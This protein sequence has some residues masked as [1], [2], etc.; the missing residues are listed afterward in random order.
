[1]G[2]KRE[3]RERERERKDIQRHLALH[4]QFISPGLRMCRRIEQLP[5]VMHTNTYF[6]KANLSWIET[7]ILSENSHIFAIT[8]QYPYSILLA[9]YLKKNQTSNPCR[10]T[11]IHFEKTQ[12]AFMLDSSRPIYAETIESQLSRSKIWEWPLL[13]SSYFSRVFADVRKGL[14]WVRDCVCRFVRLYP[15]LLHIPHFLWQSES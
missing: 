5:G 12:F 11:S 1:M 4:G 13:S 6:L 8:I 15:I 2:K 14:D 10:I 3:E 7:W 9:S